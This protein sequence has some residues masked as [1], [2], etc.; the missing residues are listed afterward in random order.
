M[1]DHGAHCGSVPSRIEYRII[2]SS[3][4]TLAIQVTREGEVVAR[5]PK[6]MTLAHIREFV[7][8]HKDWIEKKQQ[9]MEEREEAFPLCSPREEAFYREQ[10]AR[11]LRERAAYFAAQMGVSYARITIRGQ[12]TR[13]GSC[14][15]KG[16][17]NFNWKLML[18]PREVQD[19]VVVHELAHLKEMN[20]SPA[21]YRE[22]ERILPDYRRQIQWLRVYGRL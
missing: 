19:Y 4:R 10:A 13:W 9:E 5:A 11:V 1:G 22:V 8:A 14:S 12:K 7:E 3:R 15:S 21:F 20:H 16:N 18:C 6:R 17:L 2:R